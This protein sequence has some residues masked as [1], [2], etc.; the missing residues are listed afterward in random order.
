MAKYHY[1]RYLYGTNSKR[2]SCTK[3]QNGQCSIDIDAC[4]GIENCNIYKSNNSKDDNTR[5]RKSHAVVVPLT[6]TQKYLLS[7]PKQKSVSIHNS[8]IIE[9]RPKRE[10]ISGIISKYNVN[11]FFNMNLVM[12]T[13]QHKIDLSTLSIRKI[14]LGTDEYRYDC[15]FKS[16]KNPFIDS[17]DYVTAHFEFENIVPTKDPITKSKLL[18]YGIDDFYGEVYIRKDQNISCIMEIGAKK[19]KIEEIL[20]DIKTFHCYSIHT[21]EPLIS[22]KSPIENMDIQHVY[23][24]FDDCRYE[25]IFDKKLSSFKEKDDEFVMD[26]FISRAVHSPGKVVNEKTLASFSNT[27]LS[28]ILIKKSPFE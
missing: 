17:A 19:I 14:Y 23:I 13:V 15:L 16:N 27:E 21:R 22:R 5:N 7:V 26:L 3:F 4:P 28:H 12:N 11:H 9:M 18:Y 2:N 1:K 6:N 25:L 8:G 10:I 24:G 20:N